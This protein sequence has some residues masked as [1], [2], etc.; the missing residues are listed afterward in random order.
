[1]IGAL[2][3]MGSCSEGVQ[4]YVSPDGN[5]AHAGT[6]DKP[7]QTMEGAR[8]AVR[9][10]R[11]ANPGKKVTVLFKDGI[12][13]VNQQVRLTAEDSGSEKA[14]VIYKA[15]KGETPIFTGGKALTQWTKPKDAPEL[16]RLSSS[17]RDKIYV[18]DLIAAG[19]TDFGDPTNAGKRPELICN[20]QL[21][22]LA[23]WPNEGFVQ[24]GKVKGETV[25]PETYIKVHGT[26]EGVFEYI[27][28]YQDRWAQE[29]DIRLGGYWYWDWSDQ[30]QKVSQW[31]APARTVHLGE[32]YHGY[33]YKDS[34]RYFGLN[35]FCEI[36]RPGE[37]YLNRSTGKLYWYPPEGVDPQKTEVTLTCLSDP[38]MLELKDCAYITI[39]GFTFREGRGSAIHIAGGMNNL[40][41]DCR[42][43]RFGRDGVHI[44]GGMRHGVTGCYLSSFGHGGFKIAGGDRKTLTPCDHFVEHTIVENFSLFQRTYEPAIHLDGCGMRIANNRFHNSSSSAMRLEGNDFVIEYNEVSQVVNESDDQGGIDIFY[45]PS[46]RGIIIR[47]NHWSDISGGT[48]HGAAGIR[49]DDMI[50]GMLVYGNLFERCGAV[51]FGGVQI[52]GGKDN[53]IENNVFYECPFAV[54]FS[55][56]SEKRWLES[57]DS[58]VIRKKIYS[59]VDINSAIYQQKYPELKDIRINAN[60]NSITDNL[61]ISCPQMFRGLRNDQIVRNN[62][63]LE[64]NGQSIES[65]CTKEILSKYGLQPIPVEKIGPKK[66]RH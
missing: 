39:E 61:M 22:M 6:L 40:L 60:V 1:M 15:M 27:D 48:L 44:Y 66:N 65:F 7:L 45:N 34:L 33:G 63:E 5:D 42:I 54:T 24:A 19:I 47:Y 21:Q 8:K 59:D 31:D 51:H 2:F 29:D 23:R 12:Y 37:W 28:A 30:F 17:V 52:H 64:A 56:W 16:E 32:P 35:L 36:D 3:L 4:L 20:A 62:T 58:E 49:F 13:P 10:A 38:Y 9:E 53:R 14:P 41:S 55:P 57:L 18:T 11:M 43:E 25:L 50:S 26:K 46:Y